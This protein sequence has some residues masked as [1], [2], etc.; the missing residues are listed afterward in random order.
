MCHTS[1]YARPQGRSQAGTDADRKA[2]LADAN[3]A[4]C[5]VCVEEHFK[6]DEIMNLHG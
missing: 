3:D 4:D 5:N 6:N 2:K 1:D